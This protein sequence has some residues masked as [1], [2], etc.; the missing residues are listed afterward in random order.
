MPAPRLVIISLDFGYPAPGQ[1]RGAPPETGAIDLFWTSLT[2]RTLRSTDLLGVEKDSG[3]F[4]SCHVYIILSLIL[5]AHTPGS[6][7]G[8]GYL[9][10][11]TQ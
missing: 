7:I 1:R 9:N 2:S 8:L 5:R 10:P 11:G 6:Y 3:F 4:G